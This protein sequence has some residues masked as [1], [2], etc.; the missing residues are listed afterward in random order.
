[1]NEHVALTPGLSQRE[2]E[3]RLDPGELLEGVGALWDDAWLDADRVGYLGHVDVAAIVYPDAVGC[4]EVAWLGGVCA[5]PAQ[6]HVALDVED[7]EA[8]RLLDFDRAAAEGLQACS[9]DELADVDVFV[10]VDEDVLRAL[11]VEPLGQVRALGA[12]DLDA[13]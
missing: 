2:R 6:Q 4:D 10:F 13:V 9:P 8:G 7:A 12:E 1:M 3:L 5:A 11:Y